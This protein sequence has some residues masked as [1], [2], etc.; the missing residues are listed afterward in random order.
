MPVL[1]WDQTGERVYENGVDHGVLYIPNT[2]GIYDEGFAWNGLVTVT[3]S[4]AGAETSKQYADNR[5]YASLVSAEEYNATI[6]AFTYPAEFEQ[7]DGTANPTPGVALGQQTRTSFGFSYRTKVGNDLSPDAG[8]KIHLVY[9]A[10][11]APSEKSR[12]TINDSP[13]ATTFSWD[14]T[15]TPAEVGTIGAV[16]YKPVSTITVDSTKEDPDALAT[17]EEFLYGTAGTDPSLPTPA[18]V[19]AM[20]SG[21]ILTVTPTEPAYVDATNTVTIP[22]I[23]GVTYYANDEVVAPGPLVLTENTI[24]V[25][26][27]NVGY[28]FPAGV[29]DDWLIGDI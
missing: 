11:A 23:A 25:A 20:F 15:T 7:C 3:E 18:A 16:A 2:A 21:A 12:T 22:T 13:E 29:D 26:R 10:M 9:G 14:L 28:K 4:P 19:V 1:Q 17:L 5:V 24:F 8:Y 6:E 27:P